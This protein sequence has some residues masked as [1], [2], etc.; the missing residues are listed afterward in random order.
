MK[1]KKKAIEKVEGRRRKRCRRKGCDDIKKTRGR[2]GKKKRKNQV[3]ERGQ[4]GK[5]EKEEK[6]GEEEGLR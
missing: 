5:E 6:K 3:E 1:K 2:E 4:V